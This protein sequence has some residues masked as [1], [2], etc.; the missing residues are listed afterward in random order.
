MSVNER[1]FEIPIGSD[2]PSVVEGQG[3]NLGNEMSLLQIGKELHLAPPNEWELLRLRASE[4]PQ[5]RSGQ[6]GA[7]IS[8]AEFYGHGGKKGAFKHPTGYGKTKV[9]AYYG[10][11]VGGRQVYLTPGMESVYDIQREVSK[12]EPDD[13]IG[14][15]QG[16]TKQHGRRITI[17]TAGSFL[18]L[19]NQAI[20]GDA[21]AA[22]HLRFLSKAD[23]VFVDEVHRFLTQKRK[24]LLS[25]FMSARF[26]GGTATDRYFLEKSVENRFGKIIHEVPIVDAIKEKV[27]VEPRGILVRSGQTLNGVEFVQT[28]YG[29]DFN[30]QT[31][32]RRVDLRSRDL[33][34]INA[35]KELP[36]RPDGRRMPALANTVSKEHAKNYAKAANEQGCPTA[37]ITGDVTLEE[38]KRI[39]NLHEAG[40]IEIVSTV[41]TANEALNKPYLQVL[42][43]NCPTASELLAWQRLG[44]VLRSV[45]GKDDARGP[46]R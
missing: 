24:D 13:E 19:A 35:Y 38:R 46:G 29:R 36:L 4:D 28:G 25:I 15:I 10:N 18:S 20:S 33:L 45:D 16:K 6:A 27:L 5:L 34:S 23:T 9:Y 14:V 39:W 3:E 7:L 42:I 2:T 12:Y 8:F 37:V 21:Q 31:F 32:E 44:R 40:E 11:V 22:S 1:F 26:L 30:M 43:N 17:A 41:N